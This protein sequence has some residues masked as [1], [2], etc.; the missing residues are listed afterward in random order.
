MKL[1]INII[2][3]WII[4]IIIRLIA[5]YPTINYSNV[6]QLSNSNNS[7]AIFKLVHLFW[8]L[9]WF[10]PIIITIYYVIRIY[11]IKKGADIE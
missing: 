6:N 7:Y 11:N 5:Y 9:Y 4:S 3:T 2:L 8:T 1:I 10:I